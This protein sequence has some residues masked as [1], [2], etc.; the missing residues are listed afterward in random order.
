MS[1]PIITIF[2][3]L[4]LLLG[5]IGSSSALSP[6]PS[7]DSEV[8]DNCQGTHIWE[9]GSK[10][11]GGWKNNEF[12]GYGIYTHEN[13]E[14]KEGV[15]ENGVF[16]YAQSAA[17]YRKIKLAEKKARE[18]AHIAK[19]RKY[20]KAQRDK[21]LAKQKKLRKLLAR[22]KQG[23]ADAQNTLG[24]MYE[25]GDG[26]PRDDKISMKWYRLAAKQG[27][28][29][30]SERYNKFVLEDIIYKSDVQE[31]ENLGE[32]L[33][34]ECKKDIKCAFIKVWAYIDITKD[35]RLSVAEIA[36]F[37]RNIVKFAAAGE[38]ESI[39][40]TEDFAAIQLASIIF[41]PITASSVLNSFDYD[42]DGLLSKNEV[43]GDTEFSKLVGI[44]LETFSTGFDF[45]SLGKKL[46]D[47]MNLIPLPK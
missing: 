9:S 11:V 45:R 2:L 13:G 20:E 41:L 3:S 38:G 34:T 4:T 33:E 36:R 18:K 10:Y 46:Q 28:D 12:H 24:I 23:N 22:A 44:N 1:K 26:V 21:Q 42:N 37:Q 35:D 8:W 39:L 16:K 14:I 29:H 17:D 15:W 47:S 19:K 30:A 43:L 27:N 32:S 31:L 6:C 25:R 5:V 40:K 7:S